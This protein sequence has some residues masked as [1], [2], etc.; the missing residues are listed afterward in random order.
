MPFLLPKPKSIT[1]TEVVLSR[2]DW[3]RIAEMFDDPDWADELAEDAKDLAAIAEVRAEDAAFA[4]RIESERGAP[5][6][7]T[8]PVEVIEAKLDG[9]HPIKAWREHRGWTQLDLSSTAG[10]RRDLIAQIETRRK[11]GS[12]E[13]LDRIARALNVPMEAL[14]EEKENQGR[15]GVPGHHRRG[16]TR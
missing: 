6:E 7:V 9:A 13:T 14:L 4:A 15:N 12:I 10:V 2:A 1:D 11:N 16:E 8:I 3:D 5:V